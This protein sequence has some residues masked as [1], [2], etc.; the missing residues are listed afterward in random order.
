ML[1]LLAA[2]VV[3]VVW[4]WCW[5]AFL[6]AGARGRDH[7]ADARAEGGHRS[8]LHETGGEAGPPADGGSP[9]DASAPRY[10]SSTV[11]SLT[12]DGSPAKQIRPRLR[13]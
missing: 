13:M 4:R 1:G 10:D 9:H 8:Q 7:A 5:S 12:S 6:R 11:S 2:V 3:V